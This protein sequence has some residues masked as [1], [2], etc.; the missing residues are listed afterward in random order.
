MVNVKTDLEWRLQSLIQVEQ[1]DCLI[2]DIESPYKDPAD[3]Y[4]S[5][6]DFSDDTADPIE[7]DCNV[8][9]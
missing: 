5:F 4:S 6:P 7:T 9:Y 3:K 8:S 1:G 2:F